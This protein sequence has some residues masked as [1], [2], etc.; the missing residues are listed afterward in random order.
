MLPA[1]DDNDDDNEEC[2]YF[3]DEEISFRGAPTLSSSFKMIMM[4]IMK[5]A[6]ILKMKRSLLGEHLH[7]PLPA[8]DDNNDVND[9]NND[10]D[11]EE[12]NYFED[13]EI[14]CRGAP[15]PSSS[16]L[17]PLSCPLFSG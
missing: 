13:E 5:N 17:H 4:M 3:E 6:I 9:D 14:S 2:N 10:D 12:C 1:Q 7:S 16:C 15:T 11:N 8:Q